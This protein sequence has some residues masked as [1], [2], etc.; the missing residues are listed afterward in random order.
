MKYSDQAPKDVCL[1]DED[2]M[3][4]DYLLKTFPILRKVGSSLKQVPSK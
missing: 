1:H 3:P 2:K 4:K